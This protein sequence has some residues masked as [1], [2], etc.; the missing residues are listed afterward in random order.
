MYLTFQRIAR[1][2]IMMLTAIAMAAKIG[3]KETE[4]VHQTSFKI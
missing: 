1:H 3:K 4:T 2:P